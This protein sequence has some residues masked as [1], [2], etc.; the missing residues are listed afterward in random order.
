VEESDVDVLAITA[1][2]VWGLATLSLEDEGVG[3]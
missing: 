1:L 2:R 3:F